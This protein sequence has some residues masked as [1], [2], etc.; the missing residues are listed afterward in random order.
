M[1]KFLNFIRL[2]PFL[3]LTVLSIALVLAMVAGLKAE[4]SVT[5]SLEKVRKHCLEILQKALASDEAFIRSGAVR[6]AGESGDR[7]GLP[8]LLKGTR[9]F[10]PTTRQFALQGMRKVSKKEAV[11][12]ALKLLA[13]SNVWVQATALEIIAELGS[14]NMMPAIR[15]LLKAPDPMVRLGSSYAL[16]SL[17]DSSQL[18]VLLKAVESGDAIVRY[19]AITYLGKI[20]IPIT[21]SHLFT[22]LEEEQDSDIIIYSLKALDEQVDMEQLRVLEKL[23]QHQNPRVRKQAVMVMR[24]LPVQV[25][26]SRV[27]P[28]CVDKDPMV[29]VVSAMTAVRLESTQCDEVFKMSVQHGDYGVRSVGARILGELKRPDSIA[30]LT[31]G[32]N[33]PNSR[34]RTAAVRAV[35]KIGSPETF[36]LLLQMLDDSAEV[37]R[38][39]SA[40]YLLKMLR[41][42]SEHIMTLDSSTK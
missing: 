41:P 30:L 34:V 23:L 2:K 1:K 37:I 14:R 6:A 15:P 25:A 4:P 3:S 17:G 16:Y 10:F 28:L 13:D 20:N 33:D 21:R 42:K 38:A 32:L 8:L 39:Y 26:L 11:N 18:D 36:S 29:Q 7:I 40:G 24:H 22:L 12:H 5:V 31:Y 9:D 35:G 19:Q 27:I